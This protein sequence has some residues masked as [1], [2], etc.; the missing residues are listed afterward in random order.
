M[1]VDDLDKI[2]L[3]RCAAKFKKFL[4]G[5]PMKIGGAAHL[6]RRR[7]V[8]F[9]TIG[10]SNNWITGPLWL[11]RETRLKKLMNVTLQ[12]RCATCGRGK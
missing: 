3:F 7:S 10:L 6:A 9:S 4:Q 2:W 8:F 11:N 1:N 12:Q 5:Q